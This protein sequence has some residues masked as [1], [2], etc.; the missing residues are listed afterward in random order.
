MRFIVILVIFSVIA[1]SS[2]YEVAE[3]DPLEEFGEEFSEDQIEEITFV[4]DLPTRK[5]N[6]RSCIRKCQSIMKPP[7]R[8]ACRNDKCRCK[9]L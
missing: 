9:R 4:E 3:A 5:C 8:A 1:Y 2:C 7:Y 6:I